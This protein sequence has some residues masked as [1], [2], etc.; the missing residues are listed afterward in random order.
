MFSMN[1]QIKIIV[2][3]V[4]SFSLRDCFLNKISREQDSSLC[5]EMFMLEWYFQFLQSIRPWNFLTVKKS[6]LFYINYCWCLFIFAYAT[7]CIKSNLYFFIRDWSRRWGWIMNFL[8]VKN[9]TKKKIQYCQQCY[10]FY[11]TMGYRHTQHNL[12]NE[13]KK[14][15]RKQLHTIDRFKL[16]HL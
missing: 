6:D 5:W 9:T 2:Y 4:R 12:F 7:L 13:L 15:I 1:M 8:E 11:I 10:R 3:W 14:L 16:N